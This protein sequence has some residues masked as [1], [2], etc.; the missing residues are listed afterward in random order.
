MKITF[1]IFDFNHQIFAFTV[2]I[3]RLLAQFTGLSYEM[4]NIILWFIFIPLLICFLIH[5]YLGYFSLLVCVYL[6]WYNYGHYTKITNKLFKWSVDFLLKNG[7]LVN[8]DYLTISSIICL[9]VPYLAIIVLI[10]LK[11]K[12][13]T[14]QILKYN[15]ITIVSIV[16]IGYILAYSFSKYVPGSQYMKGMKIEVKK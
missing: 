9:Y 15:L 1:D 7:K 14:K 3:L 6:L 8:M 5:K 12:K 2:I 10:I 16:L 4:I 13:K 11:N